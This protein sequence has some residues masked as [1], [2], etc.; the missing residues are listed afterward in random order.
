M[1][2]LSLCEWLANTSWSTAIHQSPWAY[3]AIESVHVLTLC[4]F[5][6]TVVMLDLR[7]LGVALRRAPVSDVIEQ[8]FPWTVAGL[9]VMVISGDDKSL[10]L[11]QKV[12]TVRMLGDTAVVNGTYMLRHKV[13][14]NPVEEKGVFTHVFERVRGGWLCINSQRTVLHQDPNSKQ[15]KP[16]T[17]ESPFHIPLFSK[18]DKGPQ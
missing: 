6:G 17:T 13:G 10:Y 9:V 16:A 3:P 8:L 2:L 5:L 15:K 1:S 4:L 7:L 11:A 14:S 12:V 18:S